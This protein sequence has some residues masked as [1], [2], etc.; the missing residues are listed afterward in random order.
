MVMCTSRL[1]TET[2]LRKDS[3]PL[4]YIQPPEDNNEIYTQPLEDDNMLY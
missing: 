2:V 3:D 4:T 1:L